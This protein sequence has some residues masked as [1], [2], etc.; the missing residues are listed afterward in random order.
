M[1]YDIIYIFLLSRTDAEKYE[2]NVN[3]S[4]LTSSMDS[5]QEER[6]NNRKC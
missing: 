6:R 3:F 4:E 2:Y 5:F 1:Q